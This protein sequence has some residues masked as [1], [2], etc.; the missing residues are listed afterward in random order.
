MVRK[1]DETILAYMDDDHNELAL[2]LNLRIRGGGKVPVKKHIVKMSSTPPAKVS[3]SDME[4][5]KK[6]YDTCLCLC[7][8]ISNATTIDFEQVLKLSSAEALLSM[9]EFRRKCPFFVGKKR[10]LVDCA[11]SSRK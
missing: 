6:A 2:T 9:K 10:I 11:T 5:F 8:A 7:L 4:G 1:D 3:Q